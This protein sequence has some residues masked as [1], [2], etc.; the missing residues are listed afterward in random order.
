MLLA[1]DFSL[2]ASAFVFGQ[3]IVFLFVLLAVVAA[4]LCRRVVDD[5]I[6]VVA[7]TVATLIT[8]R[9]RV[10]HHPSSVLV[11]YSEKRFCRHSV[12]Q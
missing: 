2:S 7:V 12:E 11:R 1:S 10:S 4:H 6:I 5:E 9:A 8:N 3:S